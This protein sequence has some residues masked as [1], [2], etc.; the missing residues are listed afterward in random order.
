MHLL[1]IQI[2][3]IVTNP[4]INLV[5]YIIVVANTHIYRLCDLQVVS[6]QVPVWGMEEE[7]LAGKAYLRG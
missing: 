4:W 6:F 7:D 3:Y 1:F 5:R 2:G